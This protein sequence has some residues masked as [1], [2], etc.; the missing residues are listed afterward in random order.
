MQ[1]ETVMTTAHIAGHD[2]AHSAAHADAHGA[3]E[4]ATHTR[5][6][7]F[8]YWLFLSSESMLFTVLIACHMWVRFNPAHSAEHAILNIPL[9]SLS[10]FILLTSSFLVVRALD[11]AQNGKIVKLQRSLMLTFLMGVAFL[12]LQAYEYSHMGHEGVTLSSGLYG[13]SFFALTGF[14]G[15]HVLIGAIWCF[16]L[17][18]QSLGGRYGKERSLGIELFGLYWHFV[19]VVWIFIFTIVYLL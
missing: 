14:H 16:V 9:T 7:K 18:N 11:A 10:T 8:A 12:A 13:M 15:F 3:H 17:F 6:I 1:Q 5:N 19:D 4:A 2:V